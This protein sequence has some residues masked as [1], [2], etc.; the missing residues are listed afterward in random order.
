[1]CARAERV[2][3]GIEYGCFLCA[4]GA[5]MV[6]LL[7]AGGWEISFLTDF[8]EFSFL[9]S[10]CL[11]WVPGSEISMVS[12]C[13]S[14]VVLLGFRSG[15]FS[16]LVLEAQELAFPGSYEGTATEYTS[17]TLTHPFFLFD[18]EG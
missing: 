16:F 3:E 12:T 7:G 1:M 15:C 8:M 13:T 14:S 2:F 18:F 6:Y 11:F 5:Y 4:Q 10:Q 17:S 9:L